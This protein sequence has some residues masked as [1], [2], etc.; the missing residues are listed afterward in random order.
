VKKNGNL[1]FVVPIGKSPKII[2]NLHRIYTHQQ[3]MNNFENFEL[4]EFGL[5]PENEK[6]GGIVMNPTKDLLERQNYACGCYWFKK[7]EI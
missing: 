4:I 1:L 2:F 5:I 3:I 6:D 7:N